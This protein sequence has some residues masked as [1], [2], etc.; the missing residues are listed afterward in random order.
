MFHAH[1]LPLQ[2][3]EQQAYQEQAPPPVRVGE[4]KEKS[5]LL[6]QEFKKALEMNKELKA[7]IKSVEKRKLI[8]SR[9]G[10]FELEMVK[11]KLE[12]ETY[13]ATLQEL[14]DNA[15]MTYDAMEA[16]II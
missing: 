14:E 1:P 6:I 10:F 2:A 8:L 9:P 15:E 13:K 3:H 12:I 11:V 5:T 7:Q 4:L 16:E